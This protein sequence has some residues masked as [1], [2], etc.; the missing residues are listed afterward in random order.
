MLRSVYPRL[1]EGFDVRV[2]SYLEV[3]AE[4]GLPVGGQLSGEVVLHDS[5]VYA[6]YEDVVDEPRALLAAAGLAVAEPENA[7]RLTWCCGGPA[8]ALYPGARR[9]RSRRSGSSSSARSATECVTACPIC[10]VNLRKSANGT[11][12]FRDISEVLAEATRA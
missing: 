11:M 2:R 4:R 9:P 3:L 6:R 8:E 1:V 10:L 12:R 7:R 5:C